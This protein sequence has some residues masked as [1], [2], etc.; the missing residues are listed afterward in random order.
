MGRWLSGEQQPDE[1]ECGQPKLL[2]RTMYFYERCLRLQLTVLLRR[3]DTTCLSSSEKQ[4]PQPQQRK[5]PL[6]LSRRATEYIYTGPVRGIEKGRNR[7]SLQ[8]VLKEIFT[9][10]NSFPSSPKK[11]KRGLTGLYPKH[12]RRERKRINI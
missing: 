5:Q 12:Q 10:Y 4:E 11:Y 6:S 8:Y 2:T 1:F 9:F 3:V 7:F